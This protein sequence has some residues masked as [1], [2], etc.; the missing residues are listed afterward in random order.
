MT[1]Y[2]LGLGTLTLAQVE[3]AL[4]KA[5]SKLQYLGRRGLVSYPVD[6]QVCAWNKPTAD[7]RYLTD[8]SAAI[9]LVDCRVGIEL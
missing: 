2:L 9:L 1:T 5:G 7:P 3:A 8:V 4:P 6:K